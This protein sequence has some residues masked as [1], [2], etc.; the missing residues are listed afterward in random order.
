MGIFVLGFAHGQSP[1]QAKADSLKETG[2]LK[3]AIE[4][5][6]KV[7]ENDSTNRDNTYNYACALALD[8]QIDKAFY[9]L[10]IAT[11]KDTSVQALNDPDFYF[12]IEDKRW[13]KLQD[14]LV[15]RVEAK[16]GKYKKIALS[17]ELWRMRIKDQAFYYHLEV[18]DKRL[19]QH[20]PVTSA[21][22]ELKKKINDQN[23]K[24]ITEII[25]TQ[26]WLKKSIIKESA[27]I[28]VF[29]VIQHADLKTQKKYLPVMKKAANN[30]EASWSNLALLI[31]RVNL[32]EG[33]KQIYGSQIYRHK[34]GSFY[35][36]DLKDPAYVNQRR[37]KVGLEPIEEYVK[38][39]GIKWNVEQKEK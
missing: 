2:H 11:A 32:G 7:Y 27:A 23:L 16:Y 18:V 4:A 22:W 17:K 36:K 38:S 39:W 9:Y 1:T 30:G 19:G 15:P 20:S 10:N 24:R 25:D 8:Q 33:K 3:L 35:V 31:D 37:K 29:L 6:A 26:G 21:L 13:E 5:Y 28:T 12:M 14:K 34:D